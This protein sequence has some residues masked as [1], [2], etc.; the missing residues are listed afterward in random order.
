MCPKVGSC[1]SPYKVHFVIYGGHA[2]YSFVL[3][4]KIICVL[5]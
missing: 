5:C 4:P 2:E 1:K 3:K